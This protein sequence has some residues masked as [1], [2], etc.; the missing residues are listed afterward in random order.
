MAEQKGMDS[1]MSEDRT[2]PPPAAL[3][4]NAHISSEEQ[5]KEMGEVYQ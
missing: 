5:Y 4:K 1:L 3:Q 2:F